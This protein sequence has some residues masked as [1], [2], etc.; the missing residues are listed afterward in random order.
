MKRILCVDDD[1]D[2]LDIYE[3]ILQEQ[4][5]LVKTSIFP[6]EIIKLIADFLPDLIMLDIKMNKINGLEV[7]RDLKSS[8]EHR[9]IPIIIISADDSIHKAICDFGATAIVFKPFEIS[10]LTDLI[11]YHLVSPPEV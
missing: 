10:D 1:Q 9:C 7:C 4:G 5:Y 2:I 8:D 11:K 3:I 6:V